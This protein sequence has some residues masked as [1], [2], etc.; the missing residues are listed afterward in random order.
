MR[1]KAMSPLDS[2]PFADLPVNEDKKTAA[3]R[4]ILRTP[5]V[6]ATERT[7]EALPKSEPVKPKRTAKKQKVAGKVSATFHIN[8]ELRDNL[9]ALAFLTRETQTNLVEEALQLL[10][11]SRGLKLPKREVA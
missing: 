10:I 1:G 9:Q 2:N 8:P 5:S 6:S 11:D 7:E 3:K 4:R